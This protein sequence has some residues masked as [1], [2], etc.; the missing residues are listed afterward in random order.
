[1]KS[2]INSL[3]K[4]GKYFYAVPF[5]IFGLFHFMS[6]PE[7]AK[8]FFSDCP[9]GIYLVY[10]SGLAL[11]LAG[12]SLI[13]NKKARL[14]MLLLALLL[15][16]MIVSIHLPAVMGGSE[17]AMPALLKDIALMGAALTYAGNFK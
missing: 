9:I 1:M 5:V 13:I 11:V 12:V 17:M 3:I 10:V 14:A 4:T 6:G 7:M 15:L 2:L 8:T 16:I